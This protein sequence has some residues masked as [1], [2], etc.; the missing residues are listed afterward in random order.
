M[1]A[2][3]NVLGDEDGELVDVGHPLLMEPAPKLLGLGKE[4]VPYPPAW[5]EDGLI[6]LG[7]EVAV[8][9]E[10]EDGLVVPRP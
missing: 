6:R 8:E 3:V 5:R 2:E 7:I 10:G 9:A 1:D 4:V